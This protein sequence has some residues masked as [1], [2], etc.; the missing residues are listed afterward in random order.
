MSTLWL[1][2]SL[3]WYWYQKHDADC[4]RTASHNSH[5]ELDFLYFRN[6]LFILPYTDLMFD[7]LR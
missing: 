3:Q 6:L 5:I 7:L 2:P 4:Q 1:S